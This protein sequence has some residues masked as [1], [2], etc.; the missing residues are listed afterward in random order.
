MSTG[1][2]SGAGAGAAVSAGSAEAEGVLVELVA[3][4]EAELVGATE[5]VGDALGVGSVGTHALKRRADALSAIT[6]GITRSREA[7]VPFWR[8]VTPTKCS[9]PALSRTAP[10]A[11]SPPSTLKG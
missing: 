2:A 6:A 1:V 7:M 11:Q 10:E 4:G 3:V 9:D 5:L 8:P